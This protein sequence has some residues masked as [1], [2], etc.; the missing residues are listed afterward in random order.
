[1]LLSSHL[2]VSPVCQHFWD[3]YAATVSNNIKT[4]KRP[5]RLHATYKYSIV[6]EAALALYLDEEGTERCGR[7]EEI[8]SCD[9]DAVI[10]MIGAGC[11]R[12]DWVERGGI[13]W[14]STRI[15]LP[16]R[17]VSCAFCNG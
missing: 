13:S 5:E 11:G 12:K 2:F 9:R 8:I 15:G 16:R 6:T 4:K 3:Q 7:N 14:M 10:S 17:A 1:M